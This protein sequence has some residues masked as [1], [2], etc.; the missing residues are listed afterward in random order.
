MLVFILF[1]TVFDYILFYIKKNDR[2]DSN[3]HG[4]YAAH[5]SLLSPTTNKARRCSFWFPLSISFT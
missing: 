3:L 1:Q 2:Q 4:Y 5:L